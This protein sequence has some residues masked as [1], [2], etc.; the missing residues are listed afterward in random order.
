MSAPIT[1]E[2]PDATL[3]APERKLRRPQ[4]G[5]PADAAYLENI[6]QRI[7]GA[8]GIDHIRAEVFS[9][10]SIGYGAGLAPFFADYIAPEDGEYG[11]DT[12]HVHGCSFREGLG[13]LADDPE[14]DGCCDAATMQWK[15]AYAGATAA[16]TGTAQVA[17]ALLTPDAPITD[18]ERQSGGAS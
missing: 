10:Y 4:P 14:C 18:A 8:T 1:S 5:D 15:A 7:L 3:A 2:Q 11:S 12:P 16:S 9:A 6:A 17:S 13:Y